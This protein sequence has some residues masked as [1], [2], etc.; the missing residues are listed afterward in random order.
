MP[1][2]L[3]AAVAVTLA[4]AGSLIA[5]APRK[6]AQINF[7]ANMTE[8]KLGSL[9]LLQGA[10]RHS[11]IVAAEDQTVLVG[12]KPE[13]GWG[14][15]LLDKISNVT[16]QP[17][18][19]VINTNARDAAGNSEFPTAETIVAHD[20]TTARMAAMP[21]FQGANARFVPNK[22]FTDRLS[23]PVKT[24]G[25]STGINRVDLHYFGRGY[26]D[27]DVVVVFPQ[28]GVAFMGDLLPDKVVPAVD[29]ANGGSA[30]AFPETLA[31]AAAAIKEM[32]PAV[33]VLVPGRGPS[34]PGQIII[35]TW[36]RVSDLDEYV[37]FTRA[38]VSAGR[39][40]FA[41]GKSADEAAASLSLPEKF[42]GYGTEQAK[43]YV[44][45]I[46]AELKK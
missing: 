40:A 43:A 18:R 16:D 33:R 42:K 36:M 11:L 17:V 22:T 25:E 26:T 46:Y 37:E 9:Y 15:P 4:A 12:T 6:V 45:A 2:P 8:G 21:A 30:V 27:G 23:F 14:K 35:S 31:K 41:A 3:L 34:P 24:V 20:N 28:F 5:Q 13:P 38:L 44:S 19:V 39:D 7:F 29:M 1:R 32:K 10:G